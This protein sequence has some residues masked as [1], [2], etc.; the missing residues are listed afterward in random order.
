MLG[1]ET[2]TLLVVV[3]I[4]VVLLYIQIGKNTV[5]KDKNKQASSYKKVLQA[6]HIP[7]FYKDK[8]GNILGS[9][10][11]FDKS[12][13][14]YKNKAL[15]EL[16]EFRTTCIKEISL[17][18]DNGIEKSTIVHF[19]TYLDEDKN[20]DGGVGILFDSSK[21]NKDKSRLV[22]QKDILNLTLNGSMEGY[23]ELDIKTDKIVFSR[24]AKEILGYEYNEKAPETLTAWLHIIE[25]YDVEKV[26]EEFKSHIAGN[27][28]FIDNE[29]RLKISLHERWLN[30]RGKAIIGAN[31]TPTK[32]YGTIR[33]ITKAKSSYLL[34]EKEKNLFKE[35]V[36][37][38]PVL[39]FIKDI[40]SKYLYINDF[41]EKHIG[42]KNWENL[43]PKEIFGEKIGEDIAQNDKKAFYD[44]VVKHAESIANID[45]NQDPFNVYKFP[46][47]Y[48]DDKVLCGF[49]IDREDEKKYQD[50]IS[51]Y[52]KIFNSTTEGMIIADKQKK[53]LKVNYAFTQLTGYSE[54]E[55]L[56]QNLDMRK[57]DQN[58]MGFYE[59]MWDELGN[60]GEWIGEIFSQNKDGSIIAEL[61]NIHALKDAQGEVLNYIC[62]FQNIKKQVIEKA[63]L[64][65]MAHFDTLTNI[66]NRVMF[67]EH[68]K[69][70]LLRSKRH[71]SIVSLVYIDLDNFKEI[72]DKNGTAQ[73][74]IILQEVANR[75]SHIIRYSDTVARLGGDKFVILL[76]QLKQKEDVIYVCKKVLSSL[77]AYI[78]LPNKEHCSISAS[79]G[80]S[81]YP[82]QTKD[83]KELLE[84]A[85]TAMK[86]AKSSGKN[87]Y[88]IY[89]TD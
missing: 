42:F 51:L 77:G 67:D 16:G 75:L 50:T 59:E 31:N 88:K 12:F 47:T 21:T 9:N 58:P 74:D 44:G 34:L 48:G 5:L 13:G 85:T 38:L 33:D 52:M 17:V 4:L 57:S 39:A 64:K 26:N 66:P 79:L 70:A 37:N 41:Y 36:H 72:N 56:T 11:A 82:N 86:N 80:V 10:K 32:I 49:G 2:I 54:K 27:S 84:F 81:L 60:S 78:E 71:D 43:T 20:I 76:E 29:H 23:W 46:I 61:L 1:L 89:T 28:D 63:K 24:K 22:E 45:E 83:K 18:Y 19:S 35:F 7:I 14:T 69:E 30:V 73:G 40:S 3:V 68:L 15:K 62:I 65:K 25:S 6:S 8:D 55:A 53:I 87:C